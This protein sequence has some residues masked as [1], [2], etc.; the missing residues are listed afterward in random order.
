MG[1]NCWADNAGMHQPPA[2]PI[3]HPSNTSPRTVS[4]TLML[5]LAIILFWHP[6]MF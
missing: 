4:T 3:M 2:S 5:G 6:G 1:Q